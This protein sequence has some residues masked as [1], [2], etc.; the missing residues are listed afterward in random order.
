MRRILTPPISQSYEIQHKLFGLLVFTAVSA[1]LMSLVRVYYINHIRHIYI[2]MC[3]WRYEMLH[4]PC[5]R[6]LCL[7]HGVVIGINRL[8]IVAIVEITV[9]QPHQQMWPVLQI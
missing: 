2:Y 4:G 3:L 7:S 8:L 6:K 5:F 1:G 9:G